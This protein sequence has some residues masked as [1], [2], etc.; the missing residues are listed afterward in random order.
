[1]SD[2]T[3]EINQPDIL[4]EI[5]G[6]IEVV[7]DDPTKV[8][9]LVIDLSGPPG[10]PGGGSYTHVQSAASS[11]WIV[12]HNLGKRVAVTVLSPGG[13][14]VDAY[15]LHTSLNQAVVEFISPSTG[16]ALVQ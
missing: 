16:T 13:V 10:P 4:L 6:T 2:T 12:N 5:G 1:M 15:V 3:L 8:A 7:S 11:T 9:E 14:E